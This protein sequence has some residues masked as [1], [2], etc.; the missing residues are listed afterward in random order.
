MALLLPY[1]PKL[2]ANLALQPSYFHLHQVAR[3]T[4]LSR[5]VGHFDQLVFQ[6]HRKQ[7][8]VVEPRCNEQVR[9]L[10]L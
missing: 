5:R 2:R 7:F 8:Q 9:Q 10:V 4:Y 3:A 6:V 1:P